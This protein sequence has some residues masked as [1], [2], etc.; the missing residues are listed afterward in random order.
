MT[1]PPANQATPTVPAC[2]VAPA[3][4][5]RGLRRAFAG[6]QVLDGVDLT[7][8]PGEHVAVLGVSGAGKSTLVRALAGLDPHIEGLVRTAENRTVVFQDPLLLPWK[9]VVDNVALG[10]RGGDRRDRAMRALAEVG[11]AHRA[12]VW[13]RTLSGGEG[14]RGALARAFVRDPDL[15]LL[16]EPFR[17]LDALTR[18][19]AHAVLASLSAKRPTAVLLVT[20]DIDEAIQFADRVVV[21]AAGHI[22]LDVPIELER[23]RL[24]TDQRFAGLHHRFLRELGLDEA[25]DPFA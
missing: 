21:L 9:R 4:E 14:Q 6:E 7:V 12:E 25:G 2:E 8:A 24:P 23:P 18:R 5:V 1:A 22:S 17:S 19:R 3:V 20:H 16:D 15:L 11:L 10:L 13:P